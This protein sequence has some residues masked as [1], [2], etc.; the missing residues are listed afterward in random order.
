MSDEA[1]TL[2]MNFEPL[3]SSRCLWNI[4]CL[5][6]QYKFTLAPEAVCICNASLDSW[7]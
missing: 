3:P 1:L 5:T 6:N 2:H 4:K 7:G